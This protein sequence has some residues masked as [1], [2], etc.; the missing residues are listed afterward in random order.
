MKLKIKHWLS[1]VLIGVIFWLGLLSLRPATSLAEETEVLHVI[2]RL[3]FGPRPGDIEMVKSQGID[4]YIQAQLAPDSIPELPQLTQELSKWEALQLTPVELFTKYG[5]LEK[6]NGQEPSLEAQKKQQQE[7][8]RIRQEAVNARLWRAIASGRQLQEVMVDF[9]FNHFNVALF[10]GPQTQLWMGNYEEQIRKHS[11]GNFRELLGATAHHPS[12]LFYLDNWRN[13]APDSPGAKGQ[14]QGLNENYARELMELHTLGVDGGYTQ[15][16]VI[17]LARI[18]TGWGIA[19]RG[20]KGDGKSG[21][22]FDEQ[23]HDFGDKVFLGTTIQASGMAEVEQALDILAAH[24]HTAHF[25]SYKLAQYFVADEPP[26]S[27]VDALA[28]SFQDTNGDIRAVMETLFTSQEFS[29]PQYYNNKFKT[30][31]QYVISVMRVSDTKQPKL[32]RLNGILI[33][34]GMPTYGCITP[35]GYKNTQAAWLNPDAMLRRL[36]FGTAIANGSWDKRQPLDPAQ[37]SKTLGNKFSGET[38]QVI[39]TS[40]PNLQAGL[41]LGTKEM[42]YR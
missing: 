29:D 41:L 36:S 21:F 24:P 7:M 17:E 22:Y 8:T 42:M 40:P 2:N 9:W 20:G 28:Q 31:Y 14:F 5:P 39:E 33:Q 35:D 3:S 32:A 25:I 6:K 1:L 23:R 18:L 11:L 27:L 15:E 26:A 16:D 38:K 10:K 34:M 19:P 12:M 30:P 4:A 13:T 37:L